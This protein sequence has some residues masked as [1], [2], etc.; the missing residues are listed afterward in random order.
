MRTI[1]VNHNFLC[2]SWTLT[3]RIKSLIILIFIHARHVFNSF[4]LSEKSE[5]LNS[6]QFWIHLQLWWLLVSVQLEIILLLRALMTIP[7]CSRHKSSKSISWGARR[8]KWYHTHTYTQICLVIAAV[9][10]I[11]LILG[12]GQRVLII[13]MG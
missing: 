4:Y 13:S 9:G 8:L 12:L 10:S 1:A 5:N 7:F 3:K 11:Q 6:I 2:C